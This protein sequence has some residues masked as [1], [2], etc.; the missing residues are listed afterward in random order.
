VTKNLKIAMLAAAAVAAAVIASFALRDAMRKSEPAVAV[1]TPA[2][3]VPHPAAPENASG[4][5]SSQRSDVL[6]SANGAFFSCHAPPD[7]PLPPDGAT[8]AKDEMIAAHRAAAAYN[9]DMNR[10][11][12]CLKSTADNLEGQYRGAASAQDL[13]QVEALHTDLHN[14]AI[15]RLQSNVQRFNKELVKFKASQS[16]R[17]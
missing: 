5:T 2:T 15:D 10:Y 9:D 11:L 12:D 17:G 7:L 6:Q 16:P 13:A 1:G 14:A 4:A 8:A 3:P